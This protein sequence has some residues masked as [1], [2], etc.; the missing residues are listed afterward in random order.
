M[1]VE[2]TSVW[3]FIVISCSDAQVSTA[4]EMSKTNPHIYQ[5]TPLVWRKVTRGEKGIYGAGGAKMSW[6]HEMVVVFYV[7]SKR[8]GLENGWTEENLKPCFFPFGSDPK[9]KEN[10]HNVCD[11]LRQT[12]FQ[13][14]VVGS[15]KLMAP[16][17]KGEMKVVNPSEKGPAFSEHIVSLT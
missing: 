8:S 9:L 10:M 16:D 5:M 14:P 2:G 3:S 12:C 17:D 4:I 7:G 11:L 6:N 1:A 15:Q 13:L